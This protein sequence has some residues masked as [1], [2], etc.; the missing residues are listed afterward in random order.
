MQFLFD[1]VYNGNVE[2]THEL[3]FLVFRSKE[4]NYAVQNSSKLFHYQIAYVKMLTTMKFKGLRFLVE[5]ITM[6]LISLYFLEKA[7]Y[8]IF[9]YNPQLL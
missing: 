2:R 9:I 3:I 4:D 8:F 1:G 5:K 7:G 6:F